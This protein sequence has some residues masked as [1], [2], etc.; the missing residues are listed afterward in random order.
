M[1]IA[2]T[3]TEPDG[4]PYVMVVA[5]RLETADGEIS[6]PTP[7]RV[8]VVLHVGDTLELRHELLITEVGR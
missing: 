1:R 8:P 6:S 7:L 3:G 5:V 2:K 4:R